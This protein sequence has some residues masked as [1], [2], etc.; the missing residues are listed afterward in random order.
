MVKGLKFNTH[1]S[2]IPLTQDIPGPIPLV[3]QIPETGIFH[4]RSANIQHVEEP[5]EIQPVKRFSTL[6]VHEDAM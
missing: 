4:V 1:P 2:S 6:L 3:H 5:R